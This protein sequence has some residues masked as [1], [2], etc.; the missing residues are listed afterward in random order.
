[1]TDLPKTLEVLETQGVNVVSYGQEKFPALY[2]N[3]SQNKAN[4]QLD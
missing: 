4:L 2:V 3:K 1:M